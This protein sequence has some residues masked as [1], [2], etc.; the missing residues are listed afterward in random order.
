M[1]EL[2]MTVVIGAALAIVLA[3]L[4]SRNR[5][6]QLLHLERMAALEKGASLPPIQEERPWSSRVYLLRGLIWSFVGVA[7]IIC[8]FGLSTASR[9]PPSAYDKAFEAKRLS[10]STGISREEAAQM[11]ERDANLQHDGPPPSIALMGLIPL[12]VGLAY[13]IFYYTGRSIPASSGA[14]PWPA[15]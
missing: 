15:Q 3:V 1:P 13:L 5:K 6:Q 12:A 10:E 8:L 4:F 11:V 14:G 9:R 7:T 2:M